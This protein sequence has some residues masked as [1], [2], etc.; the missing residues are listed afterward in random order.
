MTIKPKITIGLTTF[1]SE[2]YIKKTLESL[3]A[4]DY[5]N[6]ELHVYD[7]NS[8]DATIEILNSY[9]C[10]FMFVHRNQHN[11]GASKNFE[12]AYKNCVTPYFMWAGHDDLWEK[13]FVSTI[14]N[15]MEKNTEASLCFCEIDFIDADGAAINNFTYN[16]LNTKG[17][18]SREALNILVSEINWYCLYGIFRREA[19]NN[20]VIDLNCPGPDVLIL[21]QLLMNGEIHIVPEKLFSYRIIQ[22]HIH[23][24]AQQ[25]SV[26]NLP[27]GKNNFW[28]FEYSS[29]FK[30]II[31][32]I[33][34][35]NKSYE[36]RFEMV[37]SVILSMMRCNKR[38]LIQ[39]IKEQQFFDEKTNS[40][41][42]YFNLTAL[43]FVSSFVSFIFSRGIGS[44]VFSSGRDDFLCGG[45][46]DPFQIVDK[47]S[48][49]NFNENILVRHLLL[50][51][52]EA[53]LIGVTCELLECCD[54]E[55][56][57]K[58]FKVNS[59]F[60]DKSEKIIAVEVQ[61]NAVAMKYSMPANEFE[62]VSVNLL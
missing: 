47:I 18:G 34:N 37:V 5:N 1:N 20:I 62:F 35:S 43:D 8:T 44:G 24:T 56:A 61:L 55:N 17:L 3:L 54:L 39:I 31:S 41:N 7:N 29:I 57:L 46:F 30:N 28:N 50:P 38:W 27:G 40:V 23:Y 16:K 53:D 42:D 21:A 22:K 45:D 48:F 6:I 13:S 10:D 32:L 59:I 25:L 12:Q 26:D 36:V 14:V 52:T 58:Y 4:Q 49:L 19:L 9:S 11:I 51:K 33:I 60:F 2:R 15:Y